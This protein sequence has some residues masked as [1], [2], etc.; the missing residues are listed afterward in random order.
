MLRSLG[1][2]SSEPDFIT[3]AVTAVIVSVGHTYTSIPSKHTD[4][5]LETWEL[6]LLN[7]RFSFHFPHVFI[8]F[9]LVIRPRIST[10]PGLNCSTLLYTFS[11]QHHGFKIW[12]DQPHKT[13]RRGK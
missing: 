10:L 11:P 12:H 1:G 7:I 3:R 6:F 9:L 4:I 2:A 13:Q 5:S 8:F